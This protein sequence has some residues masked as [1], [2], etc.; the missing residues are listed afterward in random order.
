MVA[1]ASE[2]IMDI[3]RGQ[4]ISVTARLSINGNYVFLCRPRT[5]MVE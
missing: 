1:T 3:I 5:Q 4:V 2:V